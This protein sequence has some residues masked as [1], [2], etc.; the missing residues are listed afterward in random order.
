[1]TTLPPAPLPG[2]APAAAPV[3]SPVAAPPGVP[4][5]DPVPFTVA[6]VEHLLSTEGM[7]DHPVTILTTAI[8]A[9]A[10]LITPLIAL[11]LQR[12]GRLPPALAKDVWTRYRTWL[13]LAPSI[14]IPVLL[15]PLAAMLMVCAASI[16]CYREYARAT[17]LFRHRTLSAIVVLGIAGAGV[18]RRR[19][20]S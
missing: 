7:F 20:G 2:S 18:R 9:G 11:A 14:L 4:M 15:C 3:D 1:M 10:L 19:R 8:V 12:A 5:D 6:G 13:I 17:G 16:L